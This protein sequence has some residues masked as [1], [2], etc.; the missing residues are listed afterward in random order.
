MFRLNFQTVV[1]F[2]LILCFQCKC[3]IGQN[4][5]IPLY[6]LKPQEILSKFDLDSPELEA[7]KSAYEQGR[8]FD[9]LTE[10]LKYF[11]QMYPLSENTT[12]DQNHDFTI[13]DHIVSHI[14]QWGPYEPADY[15]K[16]VDWQ[17]DP[18][19]DIEWVAAIYRFYWALPLADAYRETGDEKYAKA[20][21]ELTADWI[22][23]HPLENRDITHPVYTTW[24]GFPWLDIQTGIRATNMCSVFKTFVHVESFTPE[25]LGVFL[26]SIYDHQVKTEKIPMGVIHNK[27]IFEQRGFMNIVN[28]FNEFSESRRWAE[29]SL[30]RTR[31]NLLA[32]T[33]SDGVQ[34]EW[35][36]GY[37]VGVLRDAVEIMEHMTAMGIPIPEDYTDRVQKMYDY[38]FAAATPDL[39]WAM[40]GDVSRP[41]PVT[42]SR[43]QWSLYSHLI[44]ATELFGDPKYAARANLDYDNLPEEKS[45]AFTEAGMYVIR[46]S[47]GPE[48]IYFALHCSPPPLSSHDQPDNGTFELYAYGR[49]LMT[50]TGFY[51]YGHDPEK[52]AWHRQTK[53]HQTLTLDGNNSQVDAKQL[54]WYTSNNIDAVTVENK[55]YENLTHRRTVWFVNKQ[56][57]VLLDEAIGGSK[58]TLDLHFQLAV[59]DVNIDQVHNNAH[60]AYD[61]ANVLVWMNPNDPVKLQEEEGW[62]AWSYGHR[63]QRKAFR[64]THNDEMPATFLTLLVPYKGAKTPD[65]SV[66]YSSDFAAGDDRVILDVRAFGKMYQ[67]GRDLKTKDVWCVLK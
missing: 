61:D 25:F 43:T 13:A 17:W 18:R 16:N 20:F 24:R 15:G 11:R 28:K 10:M 66:K 52:R 3:T 29:L 34:R 27:A 62:F 60:T 26:A 47:W 19:G 21:V 65:V 23:K 36:A 8:R 38:I 37:H 55:S 7:V 2:F 9:A 44:K 51:T 58:G 50:D 5:D 48:Q 45:Y 42:G 46:D 67:V 33:T 32:Q 41:Y 1:L 22:S 54:L 57:F 63:T 64:C 6:S 56:F 4:Y 35:S 49:W 59:G 30:E 39:G 31:E 12:K 40:F 53:V 14:F